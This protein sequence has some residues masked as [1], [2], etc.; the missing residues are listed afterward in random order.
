MAALTEEY[1]AELMASDDP[2]TQGSAAWLAC[3]L[4]HVTASNFRWVMDKTAKGLPTAKR[5]SYLWDVVCERITGKPTEHYVNDA[6][7][8]G[9]ETE[10][11]ARMAYEAQTGSIVTQVGFLHHKTVPLCGGSPDGLI[12]DDGMIEIKALT[13]RNH[14]DLLLTQDISDYLPQML[15]LLWI[16]GRQYC[17]FVAFDPRVPAHLQLYIHR[18]ERDE[19]YIAKLAEDVI[20]FESECSEIVRRLQEIKP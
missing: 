5:T 18:V 3:R 6:M 10:P 20:A 8:H 1:I 16:T 15:G 4:G 12:D 13:T 19:T 7:L 17:D 2:N 11:L 9:T 14:L